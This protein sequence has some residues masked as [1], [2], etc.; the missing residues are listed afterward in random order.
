MSE[1]G[2]SCGWYHKSDPLKQIGQFTCDIIGCR[3]RLKSLVGS[4]NF[5]SVYG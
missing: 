3:T 5:R 2:L 1:K 4:S